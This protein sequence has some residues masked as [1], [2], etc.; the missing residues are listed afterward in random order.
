MANLNDHERLKLQEMINESD[1]DDNTEHI[2]K[3]KHSVLIRDDIRKLDTFKTANRSL[4]VR[5][6]DAFVDKASNECLFL[7]TNYT[8]IF[9]RITKDEL[10]LEIMTKLLMV[11]KM[12]ED[13]KVNQHE[14][15][16]MV[17]KVLKEL[18]I[19]SA[20]KRGDNLDEEHN[21]EDNTLDGTKDNTLTWKRYKK[22]HNIR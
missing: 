17:G 9:N 8:D 18:Y 19:D 4:Q 6:F 20:L 16:V 22:E 13:D 12:I 11:L 1:C 2:R 21:V 10:D 3:I 7:Y 14:G 5:D 15:S